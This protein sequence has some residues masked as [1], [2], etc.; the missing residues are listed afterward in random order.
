[1]QTFGHLLFLK[2]FS[3]LQVSAIVCKCYLGEILALFTKYIRE[4]L[5]LSSLFDCPSISRTDRRPPQGLCEYCRHA[6]KQN[7]SSL[8]LPPSQHCTLG[9]FKSNLT[10]THIHNMVKKV[11][12]KEKRGDGVTQWLSLTLNMDSLFEFSMV[13]RPSSSLK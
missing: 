5:L 6:P 13:L 3:Q 1:M 11:H 7:K 2:H 8:P 9:H 12:K 10:I 4:S